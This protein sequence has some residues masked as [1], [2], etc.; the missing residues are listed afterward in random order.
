[1]RI[2]MNAIWK[3]GKGELAMEGLSQ[4]FI[5]AENLEK[6]APAPPNGLVLWDTDLNI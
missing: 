5:S 1:M 3:V 4:R 2:I 6:I